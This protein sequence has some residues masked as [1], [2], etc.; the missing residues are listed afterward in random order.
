MSRP[1][2]G[3][4]EARMKIEDRRSPDSRSSSARVPR[5]RSRIESEALPEPASELETVW[6]R[7]FDLETI[8]AMLG[9]DVDEALRDVLASRVN[10]PLWTLA[11]RGGR[12]WRPIVSR[13]AF[14]VS[15]GTPP[16]P[17][18]IC[19]V[20]ELL[21]TGSLIIDDIQDGAAA[22]RGGPAAHAL[23]GVPTALN[24]ANTAYFRA[25]EILRRVLP[26]EL[27]LRALD[28]LAEEL[29]AAHLGQALD[30]ALGPQLWHAALR[31]SHYFVLARAKTGA[32]VRIAARL[33]AI[34]AG[35]D[36]RKEAVL[37]VW[38][39]ELGIA[40]QIHND[41]A[42]LSSGMQD[43]VAC[44]PTYPLLLL[45]EHDGAAAA[46]LR[47][48]LGQPRLADSEIEE[49]RALF[50]RERVVE[51]GRAAARF[52]AGRALEAIRSLPPGESRAALEKITLELAFDPTHA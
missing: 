18:A 37:G 40:Y 36:D 45:L 47:S 22:R 6:P 42:D 30:L 39:G 12:R 11:D 21:H 13:R 29:L 19:Q 15:G 9:D 51:R 32:L 50:T 35:A 34:A 20:A 44:R 2:Q 16:V 49:L 48:R 41:L 10:A 7:R 25:L 3:D 17:R 5:R 28:M 27:R 1:L 26:D 4:A 14:L 33:G 31:T 38:A 23:Y 24:A 46:T 8:R 52:A 43:V